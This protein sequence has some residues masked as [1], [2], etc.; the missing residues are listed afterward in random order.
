MPVVCDKESLCPD[1]P[2]LEMKFKFDKIQECITF[3]NLCQKFYLQILS[4]QSG[5]LKKE[6]PMTLSI[7]IPETTCAV[8]I[9][10]FL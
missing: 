6:T 4:T 1:G 9:I 2:I 5:L 3:P 7:I 8:E 10:S